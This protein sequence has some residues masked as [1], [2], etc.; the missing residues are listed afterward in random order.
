MAQVNGCDYCLSAHT[1]LG[2]N[3]AKI[4]NAEVALNR[5]GHSGDAKADAALVFAR[6][7]LDARGRADDQPIGAGL[8]DGLA[9]PAGSCVVLRTGWERHWGDARYFRHP[10]LSAALAAAPAVGPVPAPA[11][12]RRAGSISMRTPMLWA[13]GRAPRRRGGIRAA[14][15][16]R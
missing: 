10:Y 7:V 4:D 12:A 11:P 14:G 16:R 15:A 3:L 9:I 6:K 8:L 13:I 1:Y 2:L 5:T